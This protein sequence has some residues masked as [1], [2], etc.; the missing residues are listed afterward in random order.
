M[1][2]N[3]RTFTHKSLSKINNHRHLKFT[4]EAFVRNN[5]NKIMTENILVKLVANPAPNS[6]NTG[7]PKNPNIKMK[8][9]KILTTVATIFSLNSS[10]VSP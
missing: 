4:S 5:Q 7:N 9:S 6:P 3:F 10:D 8:L 2:L 1:P